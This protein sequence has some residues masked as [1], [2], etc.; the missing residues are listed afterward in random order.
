MW[1][2]HSI[3]S[4][5]EKTQFQVDNLPFFN[6]TDL[7]IYH[8][9]WGFIWLFYQG[10]KVITL[11]IHL[12]PTFPSDQMSKGENYTILSLCLSIYTTDKTSHFLPASK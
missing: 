7:F 8:L 3:L 9:M 2:P 12:F 6:F 4:Q 11:I 10:K 5:V 1:G